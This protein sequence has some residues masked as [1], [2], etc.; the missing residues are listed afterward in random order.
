M[1]VDR[2]LRI[3]RVLGCLAKRANDR[4]A[5]APRKH[6]NEGEEGLCGTRRQTF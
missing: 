2:Y 4:G 6:P 1:A 3:N 5:A